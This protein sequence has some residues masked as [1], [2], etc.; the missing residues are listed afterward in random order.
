MNRIPEIDKCL[1]VL[2][3]PTQDKKGVIC[4]SFYDIEPF[5]EQHCDYIKNFYLLSRL[6]RMIY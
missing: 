4:V 6:K 1:Y 3:E 2:S 5:W